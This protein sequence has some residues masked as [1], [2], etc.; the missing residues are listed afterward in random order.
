MCC[1]SGA[2]V[3][4]HLHTYYIPEPRGN[5][6]LRYP[7]LHHNLFSHPSIRHNEP[8]LE[9][10]IPLGSSNL[11]TMADTSQYKV[12][13]VLSVEIKK[14]GGKPLK[15]CSVNIGDEGNPI[16]VVTSASNVRDGSRYGSF[17]IS[18][19][20]YHSVLLFHGCRVR[21]KLSP[22]FHRDAYTCI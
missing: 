14:G 17:I 9:L 16:T 7:V 10:I 3:S 1:R 22:N 12:G 4:S 15:V 18:L 8:P 6:Y 13:V 11:T 5:S 2:M 19:V 21:E 20:P